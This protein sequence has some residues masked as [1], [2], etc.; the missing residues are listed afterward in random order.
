MRSSILCSGGSSSACARARAPGGS[1]IAAAACIL[2]CGLKSG[3]CGATAESGES[4]LFECAP[5]SRGCMPDC[6]PGCMPEGMPGVG[7]IPNGMF[8]CVGVDGP[9]PGEVRGP[10]ALCGKRNDEPP[11]P[12]WPAVWPPSVRRGVP[13]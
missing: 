13:T 1:G 9:K 3:C 5:G 11:V 10:V 2:P 4:K 6:M 7:I 8:P 12:G